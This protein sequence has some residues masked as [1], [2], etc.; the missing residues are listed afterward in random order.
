LNEQIFFPEEFSDEARLFF[1][2]YEIESFKVCPTEKM[3][4]LKIK[5]NRAC[6]FCGK[7]WGEVKFNSNAHILSEA[8][9]N[10]YLVSDFEC[11]SCNTIFGQYEDQLSKYLGMSRTVM[12]AQGKEGT[13]TFKSLGRT[14]RVDGENYPGGTGEVMASR[15]KTNE[16]FRYNSDTGLLEIVGKKHP[17]NPYSVYKALVKMGLSCLGEN[18]IAEYPLALD[19]ITG[20]AYEEEGRSF[21]HLIR[22]VFPYTYGFE[23]PMLFV[24]RKRIPETPLFSH[25]VMLFALNTIY[26]FA[27]PF[28]AFDIQVPGHELTF[29][30]C[31]PLFSKPYNFPTSDIIKEKLDFSSSEIVRGEIDVLPIQARPGEKIVAL[32]Q[33]SVSGEISEQEFSIDQV[34]GVHVTKVR[35][36]E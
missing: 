9:G 13:P 14:F 17:Y 20:K 18:E 36:S 24:F 19:F 29:C 28:N 7:K 33:D 5:A 16:S 34:G 30:H 35:M 31:P 26:E 22:Y 32:V 2:A 27:I 15:E 8:L 12:L 23:T 4:D 3:T 11:D 21:A 1:V 25:T 6:R 10:H